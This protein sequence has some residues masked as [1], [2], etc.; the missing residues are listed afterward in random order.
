MHNTP[1]THPSQPLIT[2]MLL[3]HAVCRCAIHLHVVHSRHACMHACMRAVHGMQQGNMLRCSVLCFDPSIRPVPSHQVVPGGNM[4]SCAVLPSTS[5][6]QCTC[7]CVGTPRCAVLLVNSTNPRPMLSHQV[8]W[9]PH[10][11]PHVVPCCACVCFVFTPPMPPF[12]VMCRDSMLRCAVLVNST[13]KRPMPGK[14][15]TS[16]HSAVHCVLCTAVHV[17]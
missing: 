4:L 11:T 3:Y 17:G 8:V 14:Q 12:K 1:A 16:M 15:A 13:I 5:N 7:T 10:A 9:K 6:Q 2:A